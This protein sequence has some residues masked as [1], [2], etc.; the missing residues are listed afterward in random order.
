MLGNIK[1]TLTH[2]MVTCM[3]FYYV[4]LEQYYTGEMNFPPINGVDEGSLMYV[5]LSF[6]SGYY[7]TV[8]LWEKTHYTVMGKEYQSN[9]LVAAFLTYSLPCFSLVGFYMIWK[10]KH[11]KTFAEVWNLKNFIR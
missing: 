2:M 4:L 1:T 5:I 9:Q 11:C 3:P 6:A 8:N 10:K 7:G